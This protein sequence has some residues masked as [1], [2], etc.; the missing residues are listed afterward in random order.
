MKAGPEPPVDVKAEE[1]VQQRA[2][3][4]KSFIIRASSS[5][6]KSSYAAHVQV[7]RQQDF[8][9]PKNSKKGHASIYGG[10]VSMPTILGAFFIAQF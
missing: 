9:I 10:M 8:K 3:L 5:S 7:N 6:S 4:K 1:V 2:R